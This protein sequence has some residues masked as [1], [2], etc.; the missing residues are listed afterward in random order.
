[1]TELQ[2][3][4]HMKRTTLMMVA[5]AGV[6]L[7]ATGA[8][9]GV[10]ASEAPSQSTSLVADDTTAAPPGSVPSE[11]ESFP[12]AT[13][14]PSPAESP[15]ST[16]PAAAGGISAHQAGAI[17]LSRAGGRITEIE[18]ESEH[19]RPVWKVELITGGVEVEV[20]VDRENGSVVKAER[21]AAEARE[22]GDDHATDD[23]GGRRGGDDRG[24]DRSGRDHP[25]DD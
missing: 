12:S 1:M 22:R 3:V 9:I 17:A 24:G 18:A 19:G 2:E 16:P 25:E 20:Y 13:E 21:E 15:A 10:A 8:T 11:T 5:A 4:Q 14:S 23:H 7:A 6:V